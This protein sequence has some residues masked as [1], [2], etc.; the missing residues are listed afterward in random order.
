M[1]VSS[2]VGD[3]HRRKSWAR[4][5]PPRARNASARALCLAAVSLVLVLPPCSHV[6]GA[7][8]LSGLRN[9]ILGDYANRRQKSPHRSGPYGGAPAEADIAPTTAP[10]AP[11]PSTLPSSRRLQSYS[12][13][14]SSGGTAAATATTTGSSSQVL[15]ASSQSGN[16][17]WLQGGN[18]VDAKVSA[19]ILA[20]AAAR[21]A[22][23]MGTVGSGSFSSGTMTGGGGDGAGGRS[24]RFTPPESLDQLL[25][26]PP[27][28]FE[29]CMCHGNPFLL[30]DPVHQD[31]FDPWHVVRAPDCTKM[32]SC[33]RTASQVGVF[34]DNSSCTQLAPIGQWVDCQPN[35]SC[36]PRTECRTYR[37]PRPSHMPSHHPAQAYVYMHAVQLCVD[38]AA[39]S[40]SGVDSHNVTGLR[41][42]PG[43]FLPCTT[44]SAHTECVDDPTYHPLAAWV[45]PSPCAVTPC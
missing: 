4:R 2:A 38:S 43:S 21:A 34:Y 19:E 41:S 23:D 27:P 24:W 1:R 16:G 6:E 5:M 29:R 11:P 15:T 20:A 33:H 45:V 8:R 13:S 37:P 18:L 35:A 7:G 9:R 10:A 14:S 30:W 17:N 28:L 25:H 26:D 44:V 40:S 31:C 32:C 42:L 3:H 36:V 12:S 22:S 39:L